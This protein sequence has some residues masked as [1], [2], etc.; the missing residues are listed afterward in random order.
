MTLSS[1][2]AGTGCDVFFDAEHFF[3]GYKRNPEFALRVARGRGHERRVD[4]R[5][6]RH[7]RRLTSVRDRGDRRATW[8][9]TSATT[10]PSPCTRTT[11]RA[12]RWPTRSPEC[13]AARRRCRARSM[14]YG[15]RTGNGNLTTVIPTLQLKMGFKALPE[16]RLDRLTQV[17]HHVAELVNLTAQPAGAV[18]GH[19]RV[20]AQGGAARERHRQGARRLRACRSR[21]G[22][23]R[24]AVRRVGDGGPGRRSR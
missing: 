17:A 8:S 16:G 19:V 12:A 11:T 4:A 3:D 22:R 21:A 20:R 15:E 10:S 13:V 23:Q 7:E 2:C 24:H 14:A 1:F 9:P 6:V 18:R 5:V